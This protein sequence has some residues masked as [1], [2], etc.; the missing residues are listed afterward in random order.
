[1]SPGTRTS[2]DACATAG[3]SG[4]DEVGER[5]GGL[6]SVAGGQERDEHGQGLGVQRALAVTDRD[7]RD[8]A[9]PAYPVVVRR[10]DRASCA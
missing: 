4:R 9:E 10:S 2:A 3:R 1:M 7:A 5:G 6:R 8:A